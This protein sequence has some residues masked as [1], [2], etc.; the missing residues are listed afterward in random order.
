M[1]SA[2]AVHGDRITFQRGNWDKP[3]FS[4]MQNLPIVARSRS[5]G[6]MQQIQRRAEQCGAISQDRQIGGC[7]SG[8]CLIFLRYVPHFSHDPA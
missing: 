1:R 8:G 7:T 6:G 5:E 3:S 4:G 2:I